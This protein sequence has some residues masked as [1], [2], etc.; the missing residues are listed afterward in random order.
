MSTLKAFLVLMLLTATHSVFAADLQKE[1]AAILQT[2]KEWAAAAAEGR[3]IDR[4]VSFWADD[5]TVYPPGMPA[6]SGKA[7]IR[8]YVE[9]SLKMP[10][11]RI[12]WQSTQVALSPDGTLGYATGIN[13]VSFNDSQGKQV[14]VNGKAVTVWRKEPSGDWRCVL[15]IWNEDAPSSNAETESS[16]HD[17]VGQWRSQIQFQSGAFSSIKDLE[18]LYVF[19]AGGTMTESS[20]YDS[21]PPVPPAY[22]IWRRTG[23]NRFEAKYE[24]YI[25]AAPPKKDTPLT[26]GWPPAGRGVLS[27][28]ITLSADGDSFTSVIVYQPLNSSG[29]PTEAESKAIGKGRRLKF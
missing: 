18:F 1:R 23:E 29:K 11:F 17:L 28:T 14:T 16:P 20:N 15:D 24:F 3:D 6:L 7:A 4:I 13:Q 22:G 25:T 27:E 8:E 10:G 9:K 5:A 2:D 12:H 21:A 26:D 19:N